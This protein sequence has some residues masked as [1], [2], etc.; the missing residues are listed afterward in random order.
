MALDFLSSGQLR[1]IETKIQTA[2]CMIEHLT[3]HQDDFSSSSIIFL[4]LQEAYMR[5]RKNS[6]TKS[7]FLGKDS[8]CE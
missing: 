7:I 6:K 2:D 3:K 4:L 1:V 5:G 8:R